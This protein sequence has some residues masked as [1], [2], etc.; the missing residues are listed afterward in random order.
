M[1]SGYKG[2]LILKEK[3]ILDAQTQQSR[4]SVVEDLL[5]NTETE[6]A[7]L[8]SLVLTDEGVVDFLALIESMGTEQNVRLETLSL[9]VAPVK[10][11]FEELQINLSAQ[12]SEQG[13]FNVLQLLESLPYKSSVEKVTLSQ[14]DGGSVPKWQATFSLNV[15]KF[16]KK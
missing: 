7:Q 8:S 4:L 12:G 1:L 14:I 10:D 11:Q 9:N 16:K 5:R 2:E 6:S 15:T 3:K 13:V